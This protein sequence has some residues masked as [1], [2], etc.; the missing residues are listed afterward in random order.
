MEN[1]I[2]PYIQGKTEF[3]VSSIELEPMDIPVISVNPLLND[4]DIEHICRMLY[5][6]ERMPAKQKE[7]TDPFFL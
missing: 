7:N 6:Y 2:T 4:S 5:Q 3:S 1:D